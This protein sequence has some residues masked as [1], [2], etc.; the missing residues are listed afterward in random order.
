M[1]VDRRTKA[2]FVILLLLM[3]SFGHAF[4]QN[5]AEEQARTYMA[6]GAAAVEMA[7]SEEGLTAAAVEFKKATEI[8]PNMPEAWFNLGAMQAK[9]GLLKVPLW[10]P[11]EGCLVDET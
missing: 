8:V 10:S 1:N 2:Y 4:A 6:R 5:N 9:I 7:R 3:A 11:E